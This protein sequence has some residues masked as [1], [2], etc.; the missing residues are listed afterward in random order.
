MS[1]GDIIGN[2]STAE[3]HILTRLGL[4]DNFI[5]NFLYDEVHI[6]RDRVFVL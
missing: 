2:L 4:V 3:Y 5:D 6:T 1:G